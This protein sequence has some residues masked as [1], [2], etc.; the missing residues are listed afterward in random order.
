[1]EE[2]NLLTFMYAVL[3]VNVSSGLSLIALAHNR[4]VPPH[5][6]REIEK[7]VFENWQTLIDKYHEYHNR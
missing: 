6:L 2:M 3:A 7:L 5:D 4:G 1:M